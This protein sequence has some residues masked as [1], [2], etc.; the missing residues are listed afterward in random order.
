MLRRNFGIDHFSS[1]GGQANM[2]LLLPAFHSLF[3]H[4]CFVIYSLFC[5]IYQTHSFLLSLIVFRSFILKYTF[6][7]LTLSIQGIFSVL[8][9]HHMFLEIQPFFHIKYHPNVCPIQYYTQYKTLDK[10]FS[11]H[12][13]SY[14]HEK[15]FIFVESLF[16]PVLLSLF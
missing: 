2:P 9:K 1:N 5:I 13:T 7:F 11:G 14:R 8:F 12:L 4:I 3:Y 16:L 6:L 15:D 10:S